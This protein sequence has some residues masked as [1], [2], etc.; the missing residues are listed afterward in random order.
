[1]IFRVLQSVF[2]CLTFKLHKFYTFIVIQEQDVWLKINWKQAK[3]Q[4]ATPTFLRI[5][6]RYFKMYKGL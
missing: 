5:G 2:H 3:Q 1:M 4:R 6:Q